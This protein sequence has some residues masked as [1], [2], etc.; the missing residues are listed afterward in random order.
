MRSYGGGLREEKPYQTF[1]LLHG[2]LG[3]FKRLAAFP[4]PEFRFTQAMLISVYGIPC[5]LDCGYEDENYIGLPAVVWMDFRDYS[6]NTKSLSFWRITDHRD[7]PL[8]W[9]SMGAAPR[10]GTCRPSAAGYRYWRSVRNYCVW[11]IFCH[12]R[13]SRYSIVVHSKRNREQFLL[14]RLSVLM[15]SSSVT[16]LGN[17]CKMEKKKL[18]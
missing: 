14:Y 1:Y 12:R 10:T 13:I 5:V 3:T 15:T 8:M 11:E 4:N 9:H 2:L 6:I 16:V 17:I 18:W 7:V